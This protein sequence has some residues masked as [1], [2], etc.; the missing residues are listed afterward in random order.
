MEILRRDFLKYCAGATA[1]LGLE[2]SPLGMLKELFAAG[3]VPSRPIY[4][5]GSITSTSSR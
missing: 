2:L 3:G 1:V 4:P 5:I